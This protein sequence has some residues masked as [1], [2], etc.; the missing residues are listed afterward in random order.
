MG[1]PRLEENVVHVAASW[2]PCCDREMHSTHGD[3][4]LPFLLDGYRFGAK[5]FE[6][7]SDNAFK[8]RLAG[9]PMTFLRGA[10][11]AGMFYDGDHFTRQGAMP[12]TVVHLLQDLGSVQSLDGVAHLHRKALFVRLLT[13]ESELERMGRIF[14][15]Q[16]EQARKH[17]RGRVVLQD[18]AVEI[19]ARTA[20][21]WSGIPI[22]HTDVVMRTQELAAMVEYAGSFG[23][24]NWIAQLRRQRTEAWAAELID[25]ARFEER[26]DTPLGELAQ[27]RDHEGE[28]LSTEVLAVELLNVLRPIVAVARFIVFAALGLHLYPQWDERFR[29]DDFSDLDNFVHEVR[30]LCPFFPVIA[31]RAREDFAWQGH[32]FAAGDRVVLDLFATNH[33]PD[34]WAAPYRFAPERFRGWDGDPNTLIPQGAGDVS[35]GHRCPGERA[36]IELMRAAIRC[37]VNTKYNVPVQNL[38]VSLSK[39]P[40]L[41]RSGFIMDVD[42]YVS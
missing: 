1:I 40:A 4:T 33:A 19:L 28:Q 24:S 11:A 12:P 9:L 23:P 21:E 10:E 18:A 8:T 41:P 5:R 22:A 29:A 39:F 26:T 6:K 20:L 2:C 13:D 36:T 3:A 16:W 37:L 14:A 17:W 35:R 42:P 7:F 34:L 27:W 31:G 15:E 38:R 30:R 32:D 25:R